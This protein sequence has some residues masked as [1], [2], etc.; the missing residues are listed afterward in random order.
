MSVEISIPLTLFDHLVLPP[1]EMFKLLKRK[2]MNVELPI[3][4]IPNGDSGVI[5][6]GKENEK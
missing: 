5:Y 4:A 2:G 3:K 6:A 1:K